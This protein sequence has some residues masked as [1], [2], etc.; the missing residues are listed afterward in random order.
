V[1]GDECVTDVINAEDMQATV[2]MQA[3]RG[4]IVEGEDRYV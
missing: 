1:R 3:A 4:R 2:Y